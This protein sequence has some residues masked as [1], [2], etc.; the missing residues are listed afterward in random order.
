MFPTMYNPVFA[1]V[2]ATQILFLCFQNPE[3]FLALYTVDSSTISH[4]VND[5]LST[6]D[7]FMFLMNKDSSLS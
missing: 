2:K 7:T 6:D 5:K 3:S 4:S 1:L